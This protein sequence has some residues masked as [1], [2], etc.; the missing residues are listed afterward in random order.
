MAHVT[1]AEG[2]LLLHMPGK[3]AVELESPFALEFV[4]REEK[5]LERHGWKGRERE[6][7]GPYS[8]R[9]VWGRQV[10]GDAARHRPVIR[11]VARGAS[12]DELYY[13]VG[14]SHSAG[15]FRRTITSGEEWRLFHKEDFDACGIGCDARTGRVVVA[16]RGADGLGKLQLVDDADRRRDT[17]TSGDGHD[18][19]PSFD[20]LDPDW[21]LFQ[22]NGVGRDEEGNVVGFGPAEIH[23]VNPGTGQHEVLLADDH[24][25]YLC[26]RRTPDGWL[27][28]IRRPYR[29]RAHLSLADQM[30]A[31]AMLPVTLGA[32]VF[33]FLD[34]FSRIFARQSLRPTG[35]PN[36]PEVSRGPRFGTFLGEAVRLDKVTRRLASGD[37]SVR[38]VPATWELRRR[39]AAGSDEPIDQH[40]VSYD[41]AP[42]GRVVYT[43]GVRVWVDGTA[44]RAG[45]SLIQSIVAL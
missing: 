21:I 36:V 41:I 23:R 20:A 32:A 31:F 24:W 25:D 6:E 9:V 45:A 34:A 27:L 4:A 42:D 19:F 39:D 7:A 40:V 38:L 2:R 8:S 11:Y 30:K 18:T 10:P 43:D 1:L 3:P 37:E 17:I 13:V 29:D 28:Y 26:P 22:S 12:S 14:M 35:G 15:L 5:R 44:T 33:G 16:S